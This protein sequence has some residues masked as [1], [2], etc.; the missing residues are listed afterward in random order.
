MPVKDED[1][2]WIVYHILS[3]GG[4]KTTASLVDETGLP[5]GDISASLFRLS[6]NLLID[7]R[8]G[9]YDVLSIP[10]MLLRCQCRHDVGSPVTIENGVVKVK[11][12]GQ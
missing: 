11:N 6:S 7:S 3:T 9:T 10:E 1:T 4:P 5:A 8:E 12:S 2:D